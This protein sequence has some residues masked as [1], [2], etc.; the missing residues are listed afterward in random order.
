[1]ECVNVFL[2]EKRGVYGI[3][4]IDLGEYVFFG[5]VIDAELFHALVFGQVAHSILKHRTLI[6]ML[7]IRA[8]NE[9]LLYAHSKK[10]I[11]DYSKV[12]I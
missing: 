6:G 12:S 9:V 3:F 11:L 1:M 8:C 7:E 4:I 2:R 5:V 10:I